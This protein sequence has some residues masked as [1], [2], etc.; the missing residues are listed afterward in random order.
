MNKK[1]DCKIVQD[2]LPNYIEKLTNEESNVFIQEHLKE[3]KECK[4]TLENMQKDLSTDIKKNEKTKVNYIKKY[5]KKLKTLKIILLI[6]LTIFVIR[7]ARNMIIISSLTDKADKYIAS[8]NYRRTSTGYNGDYLNIIDYYYK[9][10]KYVMIINILTKN[11]NNKI[12]A[13]NNGKTINTYYQAGDSKIAEL[14]AGG[15]IGINTINYFESYNPIIF[16]ARSITTSIKSVECNGKEC[17]L[18]NENL[19]GEVTYIDKETGL[20][21]RDNTGKHTT[22]E[23]GSVI[24]GLLDIRY[25]F[26]TVTDDIFIEP[27]ISE[28]EVRK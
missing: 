1:R 7:T 2:L 24:S 19:L 10:G 12:T 26:G 28:Y 25:E 11:G 9:D 4:K 20:I 18:V 3:C 15:L 14:N 23:D 27:E 6:I 16:I 8:N 5:N 17:Y 22:Q 21:I 13:Y